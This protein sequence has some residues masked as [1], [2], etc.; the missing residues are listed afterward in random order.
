MADLISE[1]KPWST[2]AKQIFTEIEREVELNQTSVIE[3]PS[4][5]TNQENAFYVTY[6]MEN[7]PD[8]FPES[9]DDPESQALLQASVIAGFAEGRR[10]GARDVKMSSFAEEKAKMEYHKAKDTTDMTEEAKTKLVKRIAR[11]EEDVVRLAGELG[12]AN[13]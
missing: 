3:T 6:F 9:N 5:R 1:G 13:Q 7:S 8:L 12:L 4:V 11:L 10:L 2:R